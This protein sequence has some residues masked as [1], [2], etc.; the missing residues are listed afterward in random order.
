MVCFYQKCESIKITICVVVFNLSLYTFIFGKVSLNKSIC[1]SMNYLLIIVQINQ[2]IIFALAGCLPVSPQWAHSAPW[3]RPTCCS[4]TAAPGGGSCGRTRRAAAGR[5]AA[6][7][8]PRRPSPRGRWW[9]RRPAPGG[10]VTTQQLV[11]VAAD[12]LPAAWRSSERRRTSVQS[13]LR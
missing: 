6:G 3:W 12:W 4:R 10:S 9:A 13:L 5:T 7:C 11:R 2:Y 1:K 8:R